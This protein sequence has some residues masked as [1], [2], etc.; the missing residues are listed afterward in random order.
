[1]KVL[2]INGSPRKDGNCADMLEVLRKTLE[3]EG[4]E[5]EVLN[6][7]TNVKPCLACYHCMNDSEIK[8][9]QDK[10]CVNEA[11][12]KVQEAD[13]IVLASPVYHGGIT[14]NLKCFIDRL[15]LVGGLTRNIFKHKVGAALCTVRRSGGQ[16]TYQQLLGVM[17]AFEMVLVTS[18]YW[19]VIHGAEKGEA[20]K[21]I[22]GVEVVE[23][24]GRNI[25]WVL[26]CIK[27][28]GV[29]P[30]KSEPRT[31]YNFIR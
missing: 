27:F 26:K 28:S 16:G 20:V 29:E 9:I 6:V 31:M 15:F 12:K 8:C 22:E 30:P 24:L 7:G 17:D 2:A 3:N 5:F 11:L 25:A 14:G 21:D 19:S 1:M 18:D 4:I 10:D 13:G 23:K